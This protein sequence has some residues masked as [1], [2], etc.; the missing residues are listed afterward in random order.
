MNE[1]LKE[2][3][4][5]LKRQNATD[6]TIEQFFAAYG[7]DRNK[8]KDVYDFVKSQQMTD[9]KESDFF[10]AYFGNAQTQQPEVKKKRRRYGI[11]FG[12]WFFGFVRD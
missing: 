5:Y 10:N 9:L 12:R 8:A 2:L 6:L 4:S 7:N 1:K 11:T 3:Y